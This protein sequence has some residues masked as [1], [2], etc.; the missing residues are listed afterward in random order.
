MSHRQTVS[1]I[2]TPLTG[3]YRET[4]AR[5]YD[6]RRYHPR[7]PEWI[8]TDTDGNQLTPERYA[9]ERE[10]EAAAEALQADGHND[11]QTAYVS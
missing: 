2:Q 10:A 5:T 9:S 8:V 11:A 1:Q 3:A 7:M 4:P 6:R